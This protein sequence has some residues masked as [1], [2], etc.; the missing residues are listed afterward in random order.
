MK[1]I[2]PLHDEALGQLAAGLRVVALRMLRDPDA[3][4]D[5]AQEAMWRVLSV[6]DTRGLPADY[7]LERYAYGTLRHVVI[8]MQRQQRH[9][10]A[11]PSWLRANERSALDELVNSEEVAR[12]AAALRKLRREDRI[13]LQQCYGR[14]EKVVDIAAATGEPAERV[15]KR[16][17]RAL[18]RLRELML[19]HDL[20]AD[21]ITE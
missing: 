12:V 11:L 8:D 6:L 13:L 7:T 20:R 1:R 15:R 5:A 18:E 3:A 10:L 4:A 21:A 9:L 2:E 17:S 19:G 16:K 14:G